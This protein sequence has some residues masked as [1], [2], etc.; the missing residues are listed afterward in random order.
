[1]GDHYN[2]HVITKLEEDQK[3]IEDLT[4]MFLRSGGQ[5]KHIPQGVSGYKK[6]WHNGVLRKGGKTKWLNPKLENPH[7]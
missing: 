4:R 6:G 3:K 1:M 7:E 2:A 5:I